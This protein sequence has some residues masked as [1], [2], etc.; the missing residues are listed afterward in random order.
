MSCF[1]CSMALIVCTYV[2]EKMGWSTTEA[3]ATQ[4]TVASEH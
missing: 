2:I 3:G 1:S 4:R